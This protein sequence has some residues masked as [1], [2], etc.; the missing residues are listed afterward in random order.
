V[1]PV[2]PKSGRLG[3]RHWLGLVAR[4]RPQAGFLVEAR[5]IPIDLGPRS[6]SSRLHAAGYA[7]NQAS[8]LAFV[9]ATMPLN[10]LDPAAVR[11][12][13]RVA[14]M[15]ID[16]ADVAASAT[17]QGCETRPVWRHQGVLRLDQLVEERPPGVIE[18]DK[19][20]IEDMALRHN[21]CEKVPQ[22]L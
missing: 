5:R 22:I 11:Q 7:M 13:E 21:R 17:G 16:A 14:K 20:T 1:L 6:D 9:D 19:L 4:R 15:L 2:H 3:Y 12:V 8:A 18:R 10:M